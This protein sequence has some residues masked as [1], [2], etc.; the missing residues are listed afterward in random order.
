MESSQPLQNTD[1]TRPL[2]P[3]SPTIG[4]QR[5]RKSQR[6]STISPEAVP[7]GGAQRRTNA[8]VSALQKG[9]D[10]TVTES[11]RARAILTDFATQFDK[12]L[13]TYSTQQDQKLADDICKVL[14]IALTS[15]YQ[16]KY[17]T[18]R[19]PEPAQA[20]QQL[21][22]PSYANKTK[23][24]TLSQQQQQ[25]SRKTN[26][27]GTGTKMLETLRE[28]LRVL[29]TVPTETLLKREDPYILKRHLLAAISG[30]SLSGIVC[31]TPTATGWA[32]RAANVFTRDILIHPDNSLKLLEIFSGSNATIPEEWHTYVVPNVPTSFVSIFNIERIDVTAQLVAKEVMAAVEEIPTRCE[33]SKY[34]PNIEKCTITWII[35][36]K[37]KVRPFR[38]FSTAYLSRPI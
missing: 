15:Y 16:D 34:G 28:E 8:V 11:L 38:I 22:Q 35:S 23:T 7:Y 24:Y 14:G 4:D 20:I 26:I 9:I 5:P 17:G 1:Y 18:P 12:I 6:K 10:A 27:K 19:A 31:I 13:A 21:R 2:E 29:V 36:F 32:V 3:S 30:V 25:Q 33:P 37:K